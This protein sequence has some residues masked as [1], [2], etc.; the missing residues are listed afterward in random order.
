M[1]EFPKP[2]VEQFF[3]TYGIRTFES[4]QTSHGSCS[5]AA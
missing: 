3:Q 4:A 5:A 2:D 1:I